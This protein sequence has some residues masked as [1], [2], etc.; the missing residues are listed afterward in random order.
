MELWVEKI[1]EASQVLVTMIQAS[2]KLNRIESV[3]VRGLCYN[4]QWTYISEVATLEIRL[5][6]LVATQR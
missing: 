5:W 3:S 6:G 4:V 2:S 1:V